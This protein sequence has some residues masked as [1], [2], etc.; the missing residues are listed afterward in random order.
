MGIKTG[1]PYA[2]ATWNMVCGCRHISPG[3]DNCYAESAAQRLVHLP[4]YATVAAGG[5][6]TGEVSM[7]EPALDLPRKWQTP[8]RILVPS[9]GDL[10]Y[11]A[12]PDEWIGRVFEVMETISWHRYLVLTKRPARMRDLSNEFFRN[13]DTP[14][15]IWWGATVENQDV[16]SNRL[17]AL[18][19]TPGNKWLSIE[20]MLGPVYRIQ[21]A[22][23]AG[24]RWVV[25][26]AESGPKR[27]PCSLDWVYA[28]VED[29]NRCGID[30]YVKQ[31]DIDGKLV[32]DIEAFPEDL[33]IRE[34]PEDDA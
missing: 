18:R 28:L 9:M 34:L 1:I 17:A 24:V 2:D 6:W 5:K 31:L 20:P 32:K 15:H 29:C 7:H 27:R 11:D 23:D 21:D 3:C 33:R 4:Q 30:V 14:N 10:F 19:S 13:L 16:F 8:Q 25:I 26:G 12:V 22:A